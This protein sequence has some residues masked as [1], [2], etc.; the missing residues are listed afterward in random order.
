MELGRISTFLWTTG[1]LV[2]LVLLGILFGRQ[3]AS[4]FPAFTSLILLN[5]VRSTALFL[6]RK[7][8]TPFEYFYTFWGMA[9]LDAVIQVVVGYEVAAK[10]FRPVG[11]WA[12]DIKGRLLLWCTFSVV[13]AAGLAVLQ[14]PVAQ[15]WFGTLILKSSL[16]FSSLLVELFVGMLTLS[17]ISGLNWNSH[18]ATIA[19]GLA[20]YS[21]S[22]IL[23][24]AANT[25]FGFGD[26]GNVYNDLQL[27][28]RALYVLCAT[29][30]AVQLWRE[31]PLARK[32]THR[33]R[34][35]VAAIQT[36]VT[37]RVDTLDSKRCP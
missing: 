28:R 33:M 13:V 24:E 17:S 14:Q 1:F 23:I 9:A 37:T 6:I 20:I 30:W 7:F 5:V 2:E 27:L 3:R 11:E 4:S 21:F 25:A 32:M 34:D 22:N 10:V 8:G 35:Q 12:A 15:V 19:Q 29:Y 18:V 16:F 31:A 26:A 36:A